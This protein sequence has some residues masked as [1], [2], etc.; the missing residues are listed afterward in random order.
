MDSYRNTFVN[1]QKELS[2]LS[3]SKAKEQIKLSDFNKKIN[4]ASDAIHRTKIASIIL[5]K[6]REITRH[7]NSIADTNKK[8]ADLESKMVKKQK[9]IFDYQIKIDKE[10]ALIDK[11]QKADTDKKQKEHQRNVN[12]INETLTH[13]ST[14]HTTIIDE[15]QQL[16]KIPEKITIL[17]LA[18]NP[19]DQLQLRLDE[20]ARAIAEMIRKTKHRDSIKLESYW[21][22]QTIDLLQAL[23]E[24]DPTIVHF[25][26]H[27]SDNDEIVFQ[28]KDGNA[29]LVSKEAI[30]QTMMSSSDNIRLVFF[31][32]C[33][34]Q[35]QAEAVAEF[36]EATIGMSTSIGDDAARIFSSQFY[37]SIGF[38]HSVGKAFQQAKAFVMLEGISEESTPQLFIKTG[39]KAEEIILVHPSK[40]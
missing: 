33:Y 29:K 38:G 2:T 12:F 1:K 18:S 19:I 3:S 31:N 11:K 14:L 28:T 4:S 24:H 26:G 27:G 7:Q 21:A 15:I 20:E 30:V 6:Q 36:V 34:S 16:K 8:I 5:S 35:N 37:S 17:F 22:L 13:H 9:E 23:N 39:L 25:S 40:K 32:T 10:Q